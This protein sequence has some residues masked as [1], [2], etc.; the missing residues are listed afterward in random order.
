MHSPTAI[1]RATK[2]GD[3]DVVRLLLK[4]QLAASS[5]R[6]NKQL[7]P[8]KATRSVFVTAAEEGKLDHM[9]MILTEQWHN[10][11]DPEGLVHSCMVANEQVLELLESYLV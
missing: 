4:E 11:I 1:H 3:V 10:V 6:E 8:N 5:V 9:R 7:D 2:H